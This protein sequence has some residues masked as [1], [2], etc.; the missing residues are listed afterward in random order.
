MNGT[1]RG[2]SY[3]KIR[4]PKSVDG[5][6]TDYQ[7]RQ[8]S[9]PLIPRPDSDYSRP[10]GHGITGP[11][12][13]TIHWN[14]G[15]GGP[16]YETHGPSHEYEIAGPDHEYESPTP[17]PQGMDTVS[18]GRPVYYELDTN[19]PSSNSSEP[20]YQ[21]AVPV[22]DDFDTAHLSVWWQRKAR[23]NIYV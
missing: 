14:D 5:P 2:N 22:I 12:P 10:V 8:Q 1:L 23:Q 16:V 9:R 20:G 19:N 21:R 7:F 13:Y 6:G 17:V 15:T 11:P 18:M 4:P 3:P